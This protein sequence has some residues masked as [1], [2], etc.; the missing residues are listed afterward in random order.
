MQRSPRKNSAPA[1][2]G[3]GEIRPYIGMPR[4]THALPA[5]AVL[6]LICGLSGCFNP[7]YVS[8]RI[9]CEITADCP[10]GLTCLAETGHESGRCISPGTTTC[11]SEAPDAGTDTTDAGPDDTDGMEAGTDGG[12]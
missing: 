5:L 2:K 12:P 10:S 9:T 8:C 4:S 3:H 7:S 6:G 1:A 11:F